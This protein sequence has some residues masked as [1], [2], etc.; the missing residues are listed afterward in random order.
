MKRK[1]RIW[2]FG[3]GIEIKVAIRVELTL[4]QFAPAVAYRRGHPNPS[5]SCRIRYGRKCLKE[6]ICEVQLFHFVKKKIPIF[7]APRLG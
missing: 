7:R 4:P 5:T 3:G 2:A 1:E 6:F